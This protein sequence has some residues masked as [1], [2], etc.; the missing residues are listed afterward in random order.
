MCAM[1]APL[2]GHFYRGAPGYFIKIRDPSQHYWPTL[3][4]WE[5]EY[6]MHIESRWRELGTVQATISPGE[7]ARLRCDSAVEWVQYVS[8]IIFGASGSHN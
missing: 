4:R 3:A 1:P 2:L 8:E 5:T 6:S 7:V